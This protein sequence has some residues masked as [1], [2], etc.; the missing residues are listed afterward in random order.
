MN[1]CGVSNTRL[2]FYFIFY[3]RSAKTKSKKKVLIP[4][5]NFPPRTEPSKQ[6]I[7]VAQNDRV[8][9]SA[10]KSS[11]TPNSILKRLRSPEFENEISGEKRSRKR[12][13]FD[14]DAAEPCEDTGIVMTL[15]LVCDSSPVNWKVNSLSVDPENRRLAIIYIYIY[16]YIY[17]IY[18]YIIYIYI[19]YIY[20]YYIIY[21]YIIYIYIYIYYIYI[22]IYIFILL[23]IYLL[24]IYILYIYIYIIYIYIYI[25]IYYI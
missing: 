2:Y 14:K 17:Y 22:F 21:I 10:A 1:T 12:L 13:C 4:T 24:Y 7:A 18:I 15:S 9:K 25:Y 23:Y 8:C 3:I 16:I 11:E 20:I 5:E 6:R 19:Y